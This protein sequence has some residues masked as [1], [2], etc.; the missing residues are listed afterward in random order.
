MTT[1]RATIL[2]AAL[3]CLM[4]APTLGQAPDTVAGFSPGEALCLGERMYREG[5]LPSG[6]PMLAMVQGDIPVDG[7]MFSCAS[8]HLRGGLGSLEGTV[9]TQPTNGAWLYQP[10]VGAR[11]NP[12]ARERL[13]EHLRRGEFRPAYTDTTLA[14]ALRRGLDPTGRPLHPVMPRYQLADRDLQVLIYYLKHL[15]AQPSPGV[16]AETM[17][18]AT[19]IAGD[20]DPGKRAA[21]LAPLEAHVQ[22]VNSQS[23]H[24]EHR[25]QHG[26][27]Y[28]EEKLS[29]YRRLELAVWE[30]SGPAAT[31]Q[32]QLETYERE[33]PVFALLGG[34]SS[35]EWRPI[36]EF[37]EAHRIPNLFPITD[38]PVVSATDWYT[39]YFSKGWY[40]EGETAA[41]FLRGVTDLSPTAKVVQV[42]RDDPAA[43]ALAQGFQDT[44]RR[45]GQPPAE[46]VALAAGER[47]DD[48]FWTRIGAG[49]PDAVLVLWLGPEDL[50]DLGALATAARA[51]EM[52]FVS[53]K[54]LGDWL[55]SLPEGVRPFTYIT[56]PYSLPGE[57]K[58]AWL[59]TRQWLKSRGIPLTHERIESQMYFVGWML[60]GAL[61]HIRHD[62]YRDHMLDV[63]DMMRDQYYA[64]AAYPRLSFGPGQRYAAKGAYIVQMG[65]GPEPELIKR[66]DWVVY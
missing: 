3:A 49:H 56:Y 50:A 47:I 55:Y 48:D 58:R 4:A 35:G 36:H 23:R 25:A 59:A 5:I 44:R 18:F 33:Q 32:A 46:D 12:T 54:L 16:T 6:E 37:C 34:I 21:M 28:K 45:L 63:M 17:R 8:C 26:P 53:G 31:W 19:V 42:L 9:I 10:L 30:L 38:L 64:I 2:A 22:A 29:A 27:F 43:R 52:V 13:P 40:Q 15:S 41:T 39:L 7:T 20:V 1:L 24:Q 11:M 61:K 57:Q 65:P 66:H 51:P 14:R 62:F 60:S